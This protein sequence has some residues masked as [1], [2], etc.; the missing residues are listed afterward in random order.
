MSKMAK[1][2]K[3]QTAAR[4][5]AQYAKRWWREPDSVP[6]PKH[7]VIPVKVLLL[8]SAAVGDKDFLPPEM[9]VKAA[10]LVDVVSGVEDEFERENA[11]VVRRIALLGK[12]M[13]FLADRGLKEELVAANKNLARAGGILA[14]DLVASAA[15]WVVAERV[16]GEWDAAGAQFV[17]VILERAKPWLEYALERYHSTWWY[18]RTGVRAILDGRRN[19]AARFELEK[20]SLKTVLW[21]LEKHAN[22]DDKAFWKAVHERYLTEVVD[23]DEDRRAM[24]AHLAQIARESLL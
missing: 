11:A 20:R 18:I 3:A 21:A 15:A 19:V 2:L 1:K 22:D 23:S 4:Y 12:A 5:A 10:M 9:V 13:V 6:A 16:T 7:E 17:R 24:E 14:L 8:L